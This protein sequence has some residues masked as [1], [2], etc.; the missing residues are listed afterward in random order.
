MHRKAW[1]VCALALACAGAPHADPDTGLVFGGVRLVPKAG[2]ERAGASYGDRRLRDVERVD[3]QQPGFSLV[4]A[5]AAGAGAKAAPTALALEARGGERRVNYLEDELAR[6]R[7]E[8]QA[9][10]ARGGDS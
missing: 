5:D 9:A 3:Y 1:L 2:A 8:W 4:F 6:T 7:G 10:S